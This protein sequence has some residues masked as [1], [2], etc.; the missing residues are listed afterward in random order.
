MKNELIALKEAIK[1]SGN[2]ESDENESENENEESENENEEEDEEEEEEDEEEE[3]EDEEENEEEAEEAEEAEKAEEA[4]EEAVEV[5]EEEA[6]KE[7]DVN[8][9]EEVKLR[10]IGILN[11]AIKNVV[12]DNKKVNRNS[13]RTGNKNKFRKKSITKNELCKM[14]AHHYM[15]R[16]NLVAAIASALPIT[17]SPGF[18]QSRISALEKG[19]VCLPPNYDIVQSLPML[20]ASSI[21]S[22]YVNNFNHGACESVKGFYKRQDPVRMQKIKEGDNE[23]QKKYSNHVQQ[24]KS[25]YIN[26]LSI[27]KEILNELLTN[28][29]MTNA[30]LKL[31]SEKTKETLDTMYSEC[32]FD[33]ILGVITLLQID[34]QMPRISAASMNNLKVALDER[35]K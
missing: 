25:S 14:I 12:P 35:A 32:Q 29:T 26:S 9:E 31:L 15:V 16:A 20:R 1:N 17:S 28:P 24:M 27:L 21:L 30:D 33:Y 6:A 19:E 5:V 3:E 4:E 34:Y 11:Q 10:K 7:D 22:R 8:K 13:N 23:L 2:N 18:C